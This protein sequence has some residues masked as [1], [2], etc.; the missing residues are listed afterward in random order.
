MDPRGGLVDRGCY[1]GLLKDD[2]EV[3]VSDDRVDSTRIRCYP[4]GTERGPR[5]RVVF[6]V[7]GLVFVDEGAIN[8]PSDLE[9]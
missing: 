9:M 4:A 1:L 5:G 6:A 8:I 2:G 7:S 3:W